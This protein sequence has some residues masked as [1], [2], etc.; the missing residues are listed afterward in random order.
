MRE[1]A[2]KKE[3]EEETY[4]IHIPEDPY[5]WGLQNAIPTMMVKETPGW[6]L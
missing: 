2:K 5:T 6:H 3:E 1:L 4:R